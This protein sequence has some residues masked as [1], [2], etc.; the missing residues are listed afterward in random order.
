VLACWVRCS[1]SG[2]EVIERLKSIKEV[3]GIDLIP[4]G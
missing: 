3:S 1:D 2:I 4:I